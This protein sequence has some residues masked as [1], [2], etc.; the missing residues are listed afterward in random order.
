[1]SALDAEC[2]TA[3]QAAAIPGSLSYRAIIAYPS[4]SASTHITL[5][6][7]R[8]I[9]LPDGTPVSTDATFWGVMHAAGIDQLADG[10]RVTGCVF[11][12][13]GAV[14]STLAITTDCGDWTS[15]TAGEVGNTGDCSATNGQ[16]AYQFPAID[17]ATARC[18]VYCIEQ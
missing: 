10:T 17:C 4:E 8:T 12:N 16:W 2:S 5:G 13:F 3:A 15:T 1:L 14:G 7:G 18:H 6:A 9:V 11:T